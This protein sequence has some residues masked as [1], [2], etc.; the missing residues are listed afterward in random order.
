[1]YK[2]DLALNNPQYLICHKSKL[3]KT[4]FTAENQATDL[5]LSN[6]SARHHKNLS[7]S[8]T[9]R[10]HLQDM[11]LSHLTVRLQSWIFEGM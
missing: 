5:A 7:H 4:V 2:K 1:M 6:I 11:T 3:N 10:L 8:Q 9:C